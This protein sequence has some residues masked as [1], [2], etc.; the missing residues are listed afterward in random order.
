VTA[1]LT[2]D[3][4]SR[5][6]AVV[7]YPTLDDADRGWLESFRAVHDP[8][9]RMLAAHFTLVFP[10]TVASADVAVELMEIAR[11][12]RA[13]SVVLYSAM[14]IHNPMGPGGHVF[15]IPAE[16]ATEI[17]QLH[18]RLYS[19]SFRPSLRADIPY[20]PHVT[21]AA[22]S[23]MA[24]CETVAARLNHDARVVRGRV[25]SIELL[26]VGSDSVNPVTRFALGRD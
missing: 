24:W 19:R 15:L 11:S 25:D 13:F 12:T 9:A 4:D 8:Q 22:G 18:D 3:S 16:G 20:R 2:A 17:V 7:A 6:Q 26:E 21:V 14:A 5:C 10:T 1:F 23:D